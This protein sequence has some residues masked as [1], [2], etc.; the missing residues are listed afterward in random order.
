MGDER[1]R[2]KDERR[3]SSV[4]MDSKRREPGDEEVATVTI[5][6][7]SPRR[8]VTGSI[9][10]IFKIPRNRE[11]MNWEVHLLLVTLHHEHNNADNRGFPTFCPVPI[12]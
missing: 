10:C 12:L 7:P 1:E 9:T 8:A 5:Q 3:K 11:D 6:G 2:E 4:G